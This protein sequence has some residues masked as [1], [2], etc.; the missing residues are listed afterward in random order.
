[1]KTE[2]ESRIPRLLVGVTAALGLVGLMGTR[3]EAQA[4]P[5]PPQAGPARDLAARYRFRQAFGNQPG[6]ISQ[7]QVAFRE[8][9]TFI[10][11][12]AQGTPRRDEFVRTARFTE[13]PV[14]IG[15]IDDRL[16]AS[17][18]RQ[19]GQASV[20]PDPF[21]KRGKI[22]PLMSDLVLW[23][24]PKPGAGPE[25]LVLNPPKLFREE[26]Y[27]FA[28]NDPFYPNFALTL[29]SDQAVGLDM[30]W[31]VPNIA[32]EALLGMRVL[33]GT[34]SATL[35]DVRPSG[36]GGGGQVALI[37]V[38]GELR[39]VQNQK[40]GPVETRLNAEIQ[41]T[42]TP[43]ARDAGAPVDTPVD[44]VGG[45]TKVRLAQSSST[46]GQTLDRDLL[47]QCR[48]P[49]DGPTLEPPPKPPKPT[50]ENSWLTWIDPDGRFYLSYP[51]TFGLDLS[52]LARDIL[53]LKGFPG[54]P[55]GDLIDLTF[56]PDEQVRPDDEFTQRTKGLHEI[57]IVR[58]SPA[59]DRIDTKGW[60][61]GAAVQH[62]EVKLTDRNGIQFMR[63]LY[64]LQFPKND[65]LIVDAATPSTEAQAFRAQV[66]E[67]LK[68][69]H[70]G[71]PPQEQ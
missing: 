67:I 40:V 60:T 26:E 65:S 38:T 59:P 52:D 50:R 10:V 47:L 45:I 48:W 3:A 71:I 34:V 37:A 27:D 49:G 15:P 21:P 61:N 30:S 29:P 57:F 9:R 33:G 53:H 35:K 46:Q 1:M 51:Q 25:I 64:V 55:T 44:A 2:R 69:F 70:L 13:R 42:F 36:S 17:V 4:A 7:Y 24:K 18:A 6:S 56:K 14:D 11:E 41:F 23:I 63:E 12:T 39:A 32:L 62:L 31:R 22:R 58:A 8:N 68:T 66:E 54:P 43:G 28:T 20:K 16:V 5:N 19:Y